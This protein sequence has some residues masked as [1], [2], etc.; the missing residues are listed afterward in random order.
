MYS[1]TCVGSTSQE[2]VLAVG[3]VYSGTK[4]IMIARALL[5]L[6]IKA[7]PD[8]LV[9]DKVKT[10][11]NVDSDVV[12]IS[13]VDTTCQGKG[14]VLGDQ[15][16]VAGFG[17]GQGSVEGICVDES[18]VCNVVWCVLGIVPP[19]WTVVE[20]WWVLLELGEEIV[21]VSTGTLDLFVGNCCVCGW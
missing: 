3:K 6:S 19:G 1:R 20:C 7:G 9:V 21:W 18:N 15:Y 4:A 16:R 10:T 11:G 14:V 8:V 2:Q 17:M 13:G 12:E 5:V